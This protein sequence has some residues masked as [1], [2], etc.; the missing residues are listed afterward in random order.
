MSRVSL[1]LRVSMV[2]LL[3]PACALNTFGPGPA[4]S[5]TGGGETAAGTT[6]EPTTSSSTAGSS[7]GGA[8]DSC[9]DGVLDESEECDDGDDDDHDACTN[10]CTLAFCGD[11]VRGPGDECDDGDGVD[12]DECDN[13]CTVTFCG[14]GKIQQ[15][16]TCDE[17]MNTAECDADCTPAECGDGYA[18][19]ATEECDEGDSLRECDDD[20]TLVACG[21]GNLNVAAGEACDD[22]NTADGDACSSDCKAATV[23]AEVV[24]G[25][26]HVCVRFET[27]AVRCWGSATSGQT[28]HGDLKTLGDEEDELPTSDIPTGDGIA[29]LCAGKDHTCARSAEGVRCWGSGQ[30]G[31]HGH[32]D[33]FVLGDEPGDLPTAILALGG[34]VVEVAC[35]GMHTCVRT[36]DDT[37]RCWG[38]SF[39]YG[40]SLALGDVPGELP[41]SE[42]PGLVDIAQV[43]L[44]DIFGCARTHGGQVYCWGDNDEGQIGQESMEPIFGDTPDEVPP[45]LVDLGYSAKWIATGQDHA[46]AV[47]LDGKVRCWG[48]NAF[49]QLGIGTTADVGDTLGEMPPAIVDVGGIAEQVV[50]GS[51]HTC[52]LLTTGKVRCWGA[53]NYGQLG[54]MGV[55]TLGDE[56]GEMPPK[57]VELGGDAV[58]LASHLGSFTCALLVDGTLRCWGS[59]QFG[60]LGYGHTDPVGDDETP[61]MAGPVPF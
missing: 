15:G 47:M 58:A 32:G 13:Q 50:A 25:L 39:A 10:A 8:D 3:A 35:G 60:Q 37:V 12:D 38:R 19:T 55:A 28:G 53:G 61:A 34:P 43:A 59:N 21:D 23:V 48:D 33:T 27:G 17:R 42:V 22:D 4:D 30:L 14:D 11:G 44:G 41:T 45:S 49:G 18:N 56:P 1:A 16:E 36:I 52:V 5:S 46:C 20:C 6:E 51:A 9:G 2:L 54:N 29:E 26:R 31:K 57:D 40:D 24:T 7:S